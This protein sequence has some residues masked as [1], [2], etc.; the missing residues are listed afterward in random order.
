M[1]HSYAGSL[2]PYDGL[3]SPHFG[4]G[5]RPM[6]SSPSAAPCAACCPR[7]QH[8]S[9]KIAVETATADPAAWQAAGQW[10]TIFAW[11]CAAFIVVYRTLALRAVQTRF[12]AAGAAIERKV[13]SITG[14]PS[15]PAGDRGPRQRAVQR[16]MLAVSTTA[17][18]LLFGFVGLVLLL[19]PDADPSTTA[20]NFDVSL[21]K[22]LTPQ[23][24]VPPAKAS[25]AAALRLEDG[26]LQT[27][28]AQVARTQ[29]GDFLVRF[30][31]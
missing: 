8:L 30:K 31:K 29:Q 17:M 14:H 22:A 13:E 16:A 4:R 6:S 7:R 19:A 1:A 21:S 20:S 11:I 24:I 3:G 12:E 27:G 26:S 25:A 18:V 5:S 9:A 2:E 10:W 15:A 28:V 23:I